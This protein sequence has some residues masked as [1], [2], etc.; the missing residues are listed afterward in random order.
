[1]SHGGGKNG[2]DL[3]EPATANAIL[4]NGVRRIFSAELTQKRKPAPLE[5][6]EHCGTRCNNASGA[7]LI[8][9]RRAKVKEVLPNTTSV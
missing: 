2:S 1:M 5:T 8:R 6:P 9:H 7:A 3:S 4:V